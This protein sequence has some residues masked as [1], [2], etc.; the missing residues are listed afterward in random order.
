M[1]GDLETMPQRIISGVYVIQNVITSDC[2]VGSSVDIARRKLKHF[3]Q[4]RSNKHGNQHLQSAYNK[5][6]HDSF[7]FAVHEEVAE[8]ED[9]VA[10]EQ[11]WINQLLPRYNKMLVVDDRWQQSPESIEL[12]REARSRQ[13]ITEEMLDALKQGR[14]KR[15]Q[16]DD[17]ELLKPRQGMKNTEEHNQKIAL[18]HTGMKSTPEAIEKMRLSK[19]G[20]KQSAETIRKRS[21]AMQGHDVSEEN[22]QKLAERSREMWANRTPE[23][24]RAVTQKRSEEVK[25]KNR[26]RMSELG[27][28]PERIE[29]SRQAT[30]GLKRSEETRQKQREAWELRKQRE[31]ENPKPKVE[32]TRPPKEYKLSA[33]VRLKM[34]EGRKASWDKKK[35]AQAETIQQ[36]T[37]FD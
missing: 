31:L 33:E 24:K 1:K 26:Q 28:D 35:A 6:G 13:E 20:T 29:R 4:L 12:I 32:D 36:Q 5:Y 16:G 9:L 17:P 30:L 14:L 11:Y 2:Y 25:E 8:R 7:L 37:L 21:E 22:R 18:A 3:H 34:S 15:L 27:K 10:R 23:E 19:L